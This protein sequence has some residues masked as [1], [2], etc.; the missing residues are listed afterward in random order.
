MSRRSLIVH[1]RYRMGTNLLFPFSFP[2][3]LWSFFPRLVYVMS[4]LSIN[5]ISDS[6]S[7]GLSSFSGRP[8]FLFDVSLI[9]RLNFCERLY[10]ISFLLFGVF[11]KASTAFLRLLHLTDLLEKEYSAELG[12]V[13]FSFASLTFSRYSLFFSCYNFRRNSFAFGSLTFIVA[14]FCFFLNAS[15]FRYSSLCFSGYR[16]QFSALEM[17][18]IV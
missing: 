9:L 16:L 13:W 3:Y 10:T 6:V 1:S 7:S 15:A 18:A 5:S 2:T 11:G 14:I 12:G 4:G 8:C 17:G